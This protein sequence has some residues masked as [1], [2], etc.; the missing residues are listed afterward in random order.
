MGVRL[1]AEAIE[2]LVHYFSELKKWNRAIN[3]VAKTGDEP[4]LENHFLDSLSLLPLLEKWG[5]PGPLLDVGSGAGFPGLALK[6][7]IPELQVTLLEPRGKRV[8]F[9]KNIIRTLDLDKIQVLTARLEPEGKLQFS[10]EKPDNRTKDLPPHPVITSRAFTQI[11][12]FLELVHPICPPGG[13]VI[14]MRG[15]IDVHLIRQEI[16]ANWQL[17]EKRIFKLP[18][19]E[20]PRSLL[21][22][23]RQTTLKAGI[24]NLSTIS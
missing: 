6:A 11:P 19:S 22:F 14:C 24:S 9:L 13:K 7:A 8:S 21:V 23:S 5:F 17:A 12:A 15:K 2:R 20:A 4:I 16:T 1:S 10:G 3:L 18:Y